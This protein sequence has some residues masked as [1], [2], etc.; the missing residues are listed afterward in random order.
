ALHTCGPKAGMI[1][2]YADLKAYLVP[3]VDNYLDHHF[4]NQTTGL[5]NPTSEELAKWI[6][7][8]LEQL[9]LPGLLGVKIHETCTSTC[10]YSQSAT[11][12]LQ[13]IEADYNQDQPEQR[14]SPTIAASFKLVETEDAVVV[15]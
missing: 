2:D 10:L 5:E 1:M 4:L 9:G 14:P 13:L 12:N 15:G 3:L 8:K 7:E 11:T 6:F